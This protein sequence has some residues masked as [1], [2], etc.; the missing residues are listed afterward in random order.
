MKEFL[1]KLLIALALMIVL[2]ILGFLIQYYFTPFIYIVI[3]YIISIPI[4][5]FLNN[6]KINNKI[7]GGL[8][9]LFINLF[10]FLLIFYLGSELYLLVQKILD[11]NLFDLKGIEK[12]LED[13]FISKETLFSIESLIKNNDV[14]KKGARLTTDGIV[15]YVFANIFVYFLLTDL[16]Y[17]K[18]SLKKII[19]LNIL[20]SLNFTVNK[21]RK[22]L[23]I[24]GILVFITTFE[25]LLGFWILG[26]EKNLFLA[27][28]CG[29]LDILPYVGTVI[30]FIPLIIY[31]IIMKKYFISIG[32]ILLY[33]LSQ[34]IREILETKYVGANLEIHPLVVL[35]SMYLGMKFLGIIGFI[36]GPSYI[37]LLK[38]INY[39]TA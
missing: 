3:L 34:I 35:L 5:K 27:I 20:K 18:E 19:P 17:I 30:V 28:L 23:L 2:I 12:Y 13:S 37:L 32:L 16:E 31:N 6:M 10:I 33:I 1:R 36:L 38:E 39:N 9:L 14:I 7:S 25:Y 21:F 22:M 26:I 8:T 24:E 11:G 29:I 4:F 15:S